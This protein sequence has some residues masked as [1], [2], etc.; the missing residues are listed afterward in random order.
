VDAALDAEGNPVT[1]DQVRG[2]AVLPDLWCPGELHDGSECGAK[3]WATSLQSTKRAAAFAAHH[4]EGCDEG[5]ERSKDHPGDAGHEHPQGTRPVRWRMR[6]GIA[7][8]STGPDGRRRLDSKRSGQLTRRYRTEPSQQEADSADQRSFSTML[9]NLL[10]DTMPAGLELVIG[11]Q[12]PVPADQV[13]VHARDAAIATR[14]DTDLI[15]WGKV[16]GYTRTQWDGLMLRLVDAADQVAILVDKKNLARLQIIDAGMLVGRHVI[17]YGRYTLPEGSRRPHVRA[18]HASVA[19][20]PRVVRR[21][22]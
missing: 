10:A 17:A 7:E 2:L 22:R 15:I 8:P 9:V 6:L 12:D 18:A 4:G 1:I 20:N 19:F 5:S 13:I 21:R 14:L 16:A 3:V 11:T